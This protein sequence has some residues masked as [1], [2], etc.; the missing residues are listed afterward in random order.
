MS[1]IGCRMSDRIPPY[2]P[3]G[4]RGG[5]FGSDIRHRTS[6][7]RNQDAGF[8][9]IEVMIALV[10]IALAAVV[11]LGQRVDIVREATR[12]RDLRTVWLLAAQKLADL[13]LDRTI[14]AGTGG[15]SAGDFG[16]LDAA[17][18]GF[19]WEYQALRMPVETREMPEPGVKPREIF[20]LTLLVNGP[21][22]EQPVVLEALFPVAEAPQAPPPGA[23]TPGPGGPGA[24]PVETS[25]GPKK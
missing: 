2:P 19:T 16:E 24:P 22:F 4:G 20:R 11:L 23:T 18:A 8:T 17:Y 5:R 15:G 7:I 3:R 14:W 1:D 12:A 13:E 21:G 6:D 10:I 9:L 25:P